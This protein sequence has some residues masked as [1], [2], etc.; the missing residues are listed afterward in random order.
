MV[1]VIFQDSAPYSR[2][3]KTLLLKN[4]VFVFWVMFLDLKV[5]RSEAKPW[6]SFEIRTMISS[7]PFPLVDT[8]DPR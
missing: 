8:L 2:V 3:L 5:P 7:S 6:L 1:L 4:R